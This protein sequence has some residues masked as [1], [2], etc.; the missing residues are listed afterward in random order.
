MLHL[1]SPLLL[2]FR[3]LAA[4]S[5]QFATEFT[6]NRKNLDIV[7]QMALSSYGHGTLRNIHVSA[8]ALMCQCG[9]ERFE[10]LITEMMAPL[11]AEMEASGDNPGTQVTL[12]EKINRL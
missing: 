9:Y 10:A 6:S 3:A 2:A 5:E 8:V 11:K 1:S 12:K 7:L 4:K